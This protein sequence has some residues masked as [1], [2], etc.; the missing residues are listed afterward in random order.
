[1]LLK[2]TFLMVL[3]VTLQI[4]L[5]CNYRYCKSFNINPKSSSKVKRCKAPVLYYENSVKCF[6]IIHRVDIEKNPGPGSNPVKC[7]TCDKTIRIN[8]KKTC[9]TVCRNVTHLKCI[10]SNKKISSNLTQDWMCSTCIQSTLPFSK[11]RD[12]HV[13]DSSLINE[14]VEYQDKHLNMLSKH[15]C[16]ASVAHMNTQCL[17][18]YFDEFSLMMNRY[19]FDIVAVSETWLKD[20]KTQ[21][22]YV[23]INGY[24]SAWK[25]R[26]SK[27]G[28]GVGFYIKEHMSF[29][30]KLMNQSKSYGSSLVVE[31]K[32]CPF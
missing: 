3:I 9:C 16:Y 14:A 13:L 30:V 24:S 18:S 26:E 25:N 32:I 29:K 17:L 22:K 12:L 15:R 10:T 7:Y 23:Q 20:N 1:M 31:T 21:L 2:L 28:V 19:H 5:N 4:D 6:N 11:V 27:T 8:S